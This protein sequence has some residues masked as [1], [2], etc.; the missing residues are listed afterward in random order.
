[1]KRGYFI[2]QVIEE[3]DWTFLEEDEEGIGRGVKGKPNLEIIRQIKAEVEKVRWPLQPEPSYL[4]PHL[5]Q[6]LSSRTLNGT[7]GS[8]LS[9]RIAGQLG[10]ATGPSWRQSAHSTPGLPSNAS[11]S[12]RYYLSSRVLYV[13]YYAIHFR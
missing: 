3:Q 13:K 1:M 2:V 10:Q 11:E 8:Q 5:Q 4:Q 7:R 12:G 9:A 6:S